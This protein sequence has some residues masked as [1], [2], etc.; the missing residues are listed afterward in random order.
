MSEISKKIF[1]KNKVK[2]NSNKKK[3]IDN[4]NE[5]ITGTSWRF[6]NEIKTIKKFKNKKKIITILDEVSHAKNRFKFYG[7]YHFPDE[8]WVPEKL[9]ISKKTFPKKVKIKKIPNYYFLDFKKKLNQL[10]NHKNY[11][12]NFLYLTQPNK[13][14]NS[15]M[16]IK[17][18]KNEKFFLNKFLNELSKYDLKKS[19]ITIRVHPSEKSAKYKKIIKHYKNL[20][21]KN[22]KLSLERDIKKNYY[23]I[24]YNTNAMRLALLNNNAVITM[25][26]KKVMKDFFNNKDI[27]SFKHFSKHLKKIH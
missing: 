27:L 20:I 23:I 9:I 11:K 18:N 13:K 4:Y 1:T 8:I 25:G 3:S 26:D 16:G 6:K 10:Q 7:K 2:I 21:I 24:G 17:T 15:S 5:I 12:K 22:S 19:H 14:V